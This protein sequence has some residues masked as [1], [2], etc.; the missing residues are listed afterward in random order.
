MNGEG[1]V[2]WSPRAERF[3][4]RGRR[5]ALSNERALRY[6]EY[7]EE[8]NGFRD[9]RGRLVPDSVFAPQEYRYQRFV[10]RDAED[11]PFV[12]T[13]ISD[14]LLT[15]AE[16]RNTALARTVEPCLALVL[17]DR[18]AIREIAHEEA[19]AQPIL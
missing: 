6:L 15:E 1:E 11:R 19:I 18:L 17:R 5:G 3:Y 8:A 12:K 16:A 14:K 10:G 13:V 7:D 9:Q 2:Y 4:Q